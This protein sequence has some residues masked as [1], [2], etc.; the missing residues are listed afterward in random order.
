MRPWQTATDGYG[1]TFTQPYPAYTPLELGEYSADAQPYPAQPILG[2]D[3][4]QPQAGPWGLMTSGDLYGP[5]ASLVQTPALNVMPFHNHEEG[6][7]WVGSDGT[8]SMPGPNNDYLPRHTPL[9]HNHQQSLANAGFEPPACLSTTCSRKRRRSTAE[10]NSH[11]ER[12]KKGNVGR[13]G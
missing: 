8:T 11:Q 10:A 4:V 6:N 1:G 2:S 3:R 5:P 12:Q 13:D 9:R 7:I